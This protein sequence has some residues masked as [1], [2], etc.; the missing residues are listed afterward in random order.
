M[1]RGLQKVPDLTKTRQT[2]TGSAASTSSGQQERGKG[3]GKGRPG[4]L[5]K[6]KVTKRQEHRRGDPKFTARKRPLS[7][8]SSSTTPPPKR[9]T[10]QQTPPTSSSSS[11]PTTSS[12]DPPA[13]TT[14]STA[15]TP[16]ELRP[17]AREKLRAQTFE[18]PVK[19]QVRLIQDFAEAEKDNAPNSRELD[20]FWRIMNDWNT[21]DRDL[22]E[23]LQNWWCKL[24]LDDEQSIEEKLLLVTASPNGVSN[25]LHHL[26]GNLLYEHGKKVQKLDETTV[27]FEELEEKF[28]EL[29]YAKYV[30]AL[31]SCCCD[32]CES[33][34]DFDDAYV[35]YYY[36][37][38][39]VLYCI[40]NCMI[41][42]NSMTIR[43][44]GV[45]KNPNLYVRT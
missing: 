35:R 36:C 8:E 12:T 19:T 30:E 42:G 24:T 6:P 18:T 22:V 28:K 7:S 25:C 34:L 23:A 14:P 21:L 26:A 1:D 11:A 43:V 29:H 5:R 9:N 27:L 32:E 20:T 4:H 3:L 39:F 38:F 31:Q 44:H 15:P 33:V 2:R 13:S 10:T 45:S 37:M 40:I 16:P 17:E 41:C